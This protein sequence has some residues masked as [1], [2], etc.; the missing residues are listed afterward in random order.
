MTGWS[1]RSLLN[2]I[3]RNESDREE[4]RSE[5]DSRIRRLGVTKRRFAIVCT[6]LSSSLE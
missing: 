5:A 1:F 4:R 6:A 3:R 2:I